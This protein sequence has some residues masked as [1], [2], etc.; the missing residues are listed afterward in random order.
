MYLANK[1][2]TATHPYGSRWYTWPL[3]Q[4]PIYYW[5]GDPLPD[6]RQG[7]I[8]LL[9]NP[10]IWWG[11]WI[12]LLAGFA[13]IVSTR[14]SLRPQP[15]AALALAGIAYLINLMPFMAVARVMF[16]YHYFFSFMFSIICVVMLWDDL[17]TDAHQHQLKTR[18]H[19]RVF[20]AVL[21]IVAVTFLFFA[22]LSYGT[23]LTPQELQTHI[24][25]PTWR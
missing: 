12:A 16:L 4:R 21:A 1:T 13:Y 8:Y 3:E 2:L 25:L 9:G 6:G 7:N 20:G 14:R 10:A 5:E 11:L 18:G 15:I 24:W 19:R 17:S 23:P 22:P